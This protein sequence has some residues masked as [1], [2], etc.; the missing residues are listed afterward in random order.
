MRAYILLGF[1]FLEIRKKELVWI[2][3]LE[4]ITSTKNSHEPGKGSLSFSQLFVTS[5]D[6][7]EISVKVVKIYEVGNSNKESQIKVAGRF[8]K[9]NWL[10]YEKFWWVQRREKKERWVN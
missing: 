3:S 6:T 5:L 8:D 10:H 1:I 9:F 2:L 7:K 4:S